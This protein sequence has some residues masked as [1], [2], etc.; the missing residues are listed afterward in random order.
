MG[1]LPEGIDWG[2]MFKRL[3]AYG[4]GQMRLNPSDAEQ[5]A[6]EAIR[7]FLDPMYA[8]WDQKKEPSLLLHLGSIFNGVAR[9]MRVKRG[10]NR[11]RLSSGDE[12]PIH[13]PHQPPRRIASSALIWSDA[14]SAVFLSWPTV[15]KLFSG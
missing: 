1:E 3:F 9:N 12:P 14:E 7:R 13:P 2:D 15:R 4:T 11:E 5:V 10:F 6:Q 8:D